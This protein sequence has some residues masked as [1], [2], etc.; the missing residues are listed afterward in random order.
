MTNIDLGKEGI[1]KFLKPYQ[2]EIMRQVWDNAD[3]GV[4]SND[5]HQH[6][7]SLSD[8]KVHRS[9][10]S[11]IFFLQAMTKEGFLVEEKKLGKG[12]THGVWRPSP[13]FPCEVSYMQE[14]AMRMV[15]AAEGILNVEFEVRQKPVA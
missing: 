4:I 5:A 15:K 6:L 3:E 11:V 13:D 10:A 12:G 1:Y 7:I 14:R 2:V 8:K 9:R